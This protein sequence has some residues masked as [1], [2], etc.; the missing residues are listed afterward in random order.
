MPVMDELP[1]MA[2]VIILGTGLP[3]SIIAAACAR[4]G[5]SVLHLDRNNF[6]G[7]LWSSFNIRTIDQWITNDRRN[8]TVSDVDPESLLRSGE[9]F[10]AAGCHSFVENVRQHPHSE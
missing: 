6:Y 4:A 5:L 1:A 2:D 8:G 7:D 3:E 10:I 9:Q